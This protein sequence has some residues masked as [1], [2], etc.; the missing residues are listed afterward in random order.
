MGAYRLDFICY[1]VYHHPVNLPD[2]Q[3]AE[4]LKKGENEKIFSFIIIGS[5][6]IILHDSWCTLIALVR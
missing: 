5:L 4:Q 6:S 1:S 3:A 2:V